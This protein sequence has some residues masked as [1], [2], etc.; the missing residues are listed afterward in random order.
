MF[1]TVLSRCTVGADNMLVYLLVSG[2]VLG[3][4]DFV[5][6]VYLS[7]VV[8]LIMVLDLYF[9]SCGGGICL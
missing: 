1:D 4:V 6:K 8:W 5:G 9:C 3:N 2:V 7:C